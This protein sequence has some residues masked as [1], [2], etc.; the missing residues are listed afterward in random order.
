MVAA[1]W[2]KWRWDTLLDDLYANCDVDP[3]TGC[4]VW[5]SGRDRD[6]YAKIYLDGRHWRAARAVLVVKTGVIG[7]HARHCCDNPPCL[8]AD[9][10]SWGSAA[11]NVEDAVQRG[12]RAVGDRHH[13]RLEPRKLA[14]ER[15]GRAKLT[16]AQVRDIRAARSVRPRPKIRELAQRYGVSKGTIDS[17]LGGKSWSGS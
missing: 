3:I 10:L 16:P 17:V 13:M 9:H 6:G 7:S 14:G 8:N 5:R 4:R 15:N 2:R 1:G 12:R 11:D